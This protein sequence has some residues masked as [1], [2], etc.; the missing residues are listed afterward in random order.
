MCRG[1]AVL[2]ALDCKE[3]PQEWQLF[4]L[5]EYDGRA[6][7]GSQAQGKRN[8]DPFQS[9]C[10]SVQEALYHAIAH[11]R[12]S[13]WVRRVL[14]A[15]R[16]DAGVH[17]RSQ[18][19]QLSVHP[20]FLENYDAPLK[21]L[22]CAFQ[23]LQY[24][25][26]VRAMEAFDSDALHVRQTAEARWYRYQWEE[27]A[28]DSPLVS[29]FAARSPQRL[30]VDAMNQAAAY[31]LGKHD[32]SAFRTQKRGLQPPPHCCVL[33]A[34]VERLPSGAIVF[35]VVANRFIYRMVRNIAG[36]LARI[37]RADTPETPQEV[38]HRLTAASAVNVVN[39][40]AP[41]HGLMLQAIVLRSPSGLV[42]F[43]QDPWVKALQERY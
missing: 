11:L 24:P 8:D 13:P 10:G 34:N 32:F 15:A 5:L 25:M 23:T 9:R 28:Y 20:S 4:F 41:G 38:Q 12:A 21:A 29:P 39:A 7:Q 43:E 31:L 37:G 19:V 6:F 36:L 2:N 14:L 3:S 42:L 40:T 30:D 26:A 35:D 18:L 17:A 27:V 33:D 16:T 1:F 22:N